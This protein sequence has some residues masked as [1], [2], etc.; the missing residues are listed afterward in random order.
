[1]C[2]FIKNSLLQYFEN[3]DWD[4]EDALIL[5]S[6]NHIAGTENY[7]YILFLYMRPAYS[8]RSVITN[9]NEVYTILY[10]KISEIRN[11]GEL[12]ILGDLNARTGVLSEVSEAFDFEE[13]IIT[14]EIVLSETTIDDNDFISHDLQVV[15][16]NKDPKTNDYGHLLIK[17]CQLSGLFI[18]N[19]RLKGDEEGCLTYTDKKGKST[20]DYAVLS[21][22]L[23]NN[24][25]EFHVL[26]PSVF[27]DHNPICLF[28]KN[29]HFSTLKNCCENENH[30]FIDKCNSSHYYYNLNDKS[31]SLFVSRLNDD[32]SLFNLHAIIDILNDSAVE[33]N[34]IIDKCI[35]A[36]QC[37]IEYA[38]E[39]F[40]K[41]K[42]KHT[43][44]STASKSNQEWYDTECKN[45]KKDFD[46][47]I[48]IFKET[49]SDDDLNNLCTIRNKYR[50]LCRKK[51]R[52]NKEKNAKNLVSL[53]KDNSKAF[54]KKIKRKK[55][56][57]QNLSCDFDTHFKNLYE[58]NTSTVS[59]NVNAVLNAFDINENEIKDDFLDKPFSLQELD[60]AIKK[61]KHNKSQGSD[62]VLN[63]FLKDNTQLF[64]DAML[65]VFNAIF[66]KAFFPT[67]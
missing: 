46:L 44:Y 10:E 20:I 47:A 3:I 28:M 38:A 23:M 56:K 6:K 22:G 54:W 41:R 29:L 8:S 13:D 19:G 17:L 16:K 15:R 40:L 59:E 33:D 67:A 60:F 11:N 61:L 26:L 64:R 4:F 62:N 55:K 65:S 43:S 58:S 34:V 35:Y 32:F 48:D 49:N 66:S 45:M 57:Q 7:L 27:S 21:K 25:S 18:C 37:V 14:G 1:M 2:L 53:S 63:E 51:N 39:P 36:L 50:T 5:K 31:S 52:I 42:A 30:D 24:A 9:E 12:I